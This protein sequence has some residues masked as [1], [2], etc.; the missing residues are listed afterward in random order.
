MVEKIRNGYDC[1]ISM[2]SRAQIQVMVIIHKTN[3]LL[4]YIGCNCLVATVQD[5]KKT[6]TNQISSVQ[7]NTLLTVYQKQIAILDTN[8]DKD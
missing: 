6:Q 5:K 3:V 1:W 4:F 7:I 8:K 2:R